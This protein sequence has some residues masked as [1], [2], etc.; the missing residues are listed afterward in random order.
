MGRQW[1]PTIKGGST[2]G[3]PSPPAVW[4]RETGELGTPDIRDLER[5]QGL[6]EDWTVDGSSFKGARWSLVGNAICVE[7]AAWLGGRMMRP[8]SWTD[9]GSALRPGDRWPNAAHGGPGRPVTTANVTTWPVARPYQSLRS[10][11][12]HPLK[13]LSSRATRG[14]LNRVSRSKGICFPPGFLDSVRAHEAMMRGD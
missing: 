6:P 1:W 7:V 2:V 5:L 10:F 8:G 11:L 9:N 12:R 3:I 14:Y 13:P 4:I